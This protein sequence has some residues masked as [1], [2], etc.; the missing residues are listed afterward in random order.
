MSTQ[1]I[2]EKFRRRKRYG[3]SPIKSAEPGGTYQSGV[4]D[5]DDEQEDIRKSKLIFKKRSLLSKVK[6]HHNKI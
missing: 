4:I 5:D 2:L 1:E 6:R 3:R